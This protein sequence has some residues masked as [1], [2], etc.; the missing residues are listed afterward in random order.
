MCHQ[1]VI[2]VSFTSLRPFFPHEELLESRMATTKQNT[3]KCKRGCRKTQIDE[4][5]KNHSKRRNRGKRKMYV[6]KALATSK[7]EEGTIRF[8]KR[9]EARIESLIPRIWCLVRNLRLARCTRICGVRSILQ[10]LLRT[11][12]AV[13]GRGASVARGNSTLAAKY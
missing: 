7:R 9:E 13:G 3:I 11:D 12:V 4:R 6:T 10:P 8:K 1:R 2:P 5:G